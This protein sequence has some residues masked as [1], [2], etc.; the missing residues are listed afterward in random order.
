MKQLIILLLII[1]H[2]QVSL[3]QSTDTLF[4]TGKVKSEWSFL[5]FRYQRIQ[6]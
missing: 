1:L 6:E 2:Q 4:V 5:N 3:A